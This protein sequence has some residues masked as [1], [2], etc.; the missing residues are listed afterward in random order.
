MILSTPSVFKQAKCNILTD[1]GG[2]IVG[3]NKDTVG[4]CDQTVVMV[5]LFVVTG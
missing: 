2:S 3:E 1:G 4:H 5:V